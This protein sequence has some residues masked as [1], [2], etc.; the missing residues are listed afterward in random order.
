MFTKI[1]VPVALFGTMLLPLAA[2]ARPNHGVDARQHRQQ[3]RIGQG[4]R[5]GQLTT[6]EAIQLE[7]RE[8]RLRRQERWMHHT[9]HHLSW[10][11][12]ARLQREE[13]RLSYGIY[14]QKHDRQHRF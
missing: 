12:R 6:H 4:L 9:G 2:Q 11:E 14:R 7:R 10:R 1:L 8:A 3:E 5:T 13:N